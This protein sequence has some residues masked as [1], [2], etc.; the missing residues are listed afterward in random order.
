MRIWSLLLLFSGYIIGSSTAL[1]E[2]TL[3]KAQY[4]IRMALDEIFTDNAR[5]V[6]TNPDTEIKA[7]FKQQTPRVTVLACSDS[8]FQSSKIDDNPINDLFFVRNIG[9]QINTLAGSIEYGIKKLHTPVLLIIGHTDCGAIKAV[10]GDYSKE[11][12]KIRQELDN[13]VIAKN[14]SPSQ[15]VVINV[16]NQVDIAIKKFTK[17]LENKELVI[18]G[19]VYDF[20]NEYKQGYN[21]LILINLNGERNPEKIKNAPYLYGLENNVAIGVKN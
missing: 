3:D 1:A 14:L 9:N 21:R 7:I 2:L 18:V 13:L 5:Y 19:T 17:E 20:Q 16:H 6:K 4:D 12:E 8:R 11:S 10:L 15:A